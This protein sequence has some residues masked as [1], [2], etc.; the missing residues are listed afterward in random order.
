MVHLFFH[1]SSLARL[2][3]KIW[4]FGIFSVIFISIAQEMKTYEIWL[5]S[6]FSEKRNRRNEW[7]ACFIFYSVVHWILYPIPRIVRRRTYFSFRNS[8]HIV[9][10][11]FYITNDTWVS[12]INSQ[13]NI[14]NTISMTYGKKCPL[15]ISKSL[16]SLSGWRTSYLSFGF[17]RILDRNKKR[18]LYFK[19]IV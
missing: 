12:Y 4:T 7:E 19:L 17:G 6:G 5:I 10:S 14:N 1:C 13:S 16:I 11:Y 18:G 3:I 8:F 15:F 2:F 9:V